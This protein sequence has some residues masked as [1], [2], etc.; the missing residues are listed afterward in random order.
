MVPSGVKGYGKLKGRNVRSPSDAPSRWI[1]LFVGLLATALLLLGCGRQPNLFD[2]HGIGRPRPRTGRYA[3]ATIGGAT[4][5]DLDDVGMHSYYTGRRWERNGIVYTCRAGH[6]DLAHVRKSA[7]WTA[8]A[9][10]KVVAVIGKGQT[11][12]S[13]KVSDPVRYFVTLRYPCDWNERP[14][15]EKRRL[16]TEVA[17]ELGQYLGFAISAWHEIITWFGYRNIPLY[18]EFP[19]AFSWEDSFSDLLGSHLGAAA[20]RDTVR[21]FDI[22]MTLALKNEL[23]MLG[24]QPK[25]I[26][27]KAARQVE[28]NWYSDGFLFLVQMNK[29]NLDLGV[30]DGH[31][32][33]W[34]VRDLDAC[35]GAEPRAYAVPSL[36]GLCE[37]GFTA[38][39]EIEPGGLERNK[40]LQVVYPDPNKRA[41]RIEP[42]LH[43]RPIME[44]IR[45]EAIERFGPEVDV[46]W[47]DETPGN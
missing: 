44:H 24:A 40:I 31:I 41:D 32:T 22:A 39:V 11:E 47:P 1:V 16:A 10:E 45:W 33:P 5:L 2:E 14:A 17:I 6:V 9:A 36:S 30:D 38:K 21:P 23:E 26:A 7:D 37:L 12:F 27:A 25:N 8:Y 19:S 29:R 20:L 42:D 46:P 34:I 3:T 35:P 15:T 18:P 43:F 28:C 4:F 13:L